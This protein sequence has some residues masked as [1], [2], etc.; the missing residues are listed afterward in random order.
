VSDP[1]CPLP[2]KAC[3]DF[4][5][6]REFERRFEY[7]VREICARMGAGIMPVSQALPLLLRAQEVARAEEKRNADAA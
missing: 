3:A 6:D 1:I 5:A 7:Y 4:A 2:D